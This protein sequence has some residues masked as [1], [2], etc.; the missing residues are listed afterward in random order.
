MET[1][2]E[3]LASSPDQ[4]VERE[5]GL[6]FLDYLLNKIKENQEEIKNRESFEAL[7][8]QL[9]KEFPDEAITVEILFGFKDVL[10]IQKAIYEH[11]RF[12][13]RTM[14]GGEIK[15]KFR[16]LTQWQFTTAFFIFNVGRDKEY[17]QKFWAIIE[18]LNRIFTPEFSCWGRFRNGIAGQVALHR[19][20]ER[21]HGKMS[22]PDEDAFEK[23]D[24]WL[25]GGA[26]EIE[27]AIQLKCKQGSEE[28]VFIEVDKISYPSVLVKR[29]G[30]AETHYSEAEILNII[31][32]RESC[33][34][35]AERNKRPIKA[36]YVI[37][38]K[39][40]VDLDTGMP[41][42]ALS[43]KFEEMAKQSLN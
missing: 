10:E 15:D 28:I 40:M 22:T 16:T 8:R 29:G 34:V 23:I 11:H 24:F 43:K 33:Q 42:P 18:K 20:L 21:Y 35:L 27:K 26:G 32:F 19:L 7:K 30:G 36:F 4:M 6:N 1:S 31:H 41:Q 38:P 37:L 5:R 14:K 3:V 39:K 25:P 2:K 13:K 9:L 17:A 12:K